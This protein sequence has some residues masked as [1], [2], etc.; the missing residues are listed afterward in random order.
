MRRMVYI[1]VLLVLA[2]CSGRAPEFA[3]D[4]GVVAKRSYG[5]GE[6]FTVFTVVDTVEA[7]MLT[8]WYFGVNSSKTPWS[9][10]TP[11]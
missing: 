3:L 6:S 4:G 2:A 7:F 1:S 8:L 11:T 5:T 9:S 10:Q